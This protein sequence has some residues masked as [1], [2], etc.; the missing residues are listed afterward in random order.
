VK[1]SCKIKKASYSLINNCYRRQNYYDYI[2][3]GAITIIIVVAARAQDA[4]T[5][6]WLRRSNGT[7]EQRFGCYAN[8]R[9]AHVPGGT[10][11]GARYARPSGYS[12]FSE[13]ASSLSAARGSEQQSGRRQRHA[14]HLFCRPDQCIRCSYV[15]DN[16][17]LISE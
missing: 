16:I 4:T 8:G 1:T 13:E 14:V 7:D 6:S 5:K 15:D 2:G 3:T 10:T 12:R 17:C 9:R 11:P